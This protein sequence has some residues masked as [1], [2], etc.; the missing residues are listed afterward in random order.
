MRLKDLFI[1]E[2]EQLRVRVKQEWFKG[3]EVERK[4]C[5][6]SW[7]LKNTISCSQHVW[8]V[9]ASSACVHVICVSAGAR[10]S[11]HCVYRSENKLQAL[12][13]PWATGIVLQSFCSQCFFSAEPSAGLIVNSQF[14][15][16]GL[17]R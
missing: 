13:P 11:Q 4:Q 16:L 9:C 2:T 5:T 6:N 7:G 8:Y 12:C 1:A 3:A 15:Y 10:M 17:I 14:S